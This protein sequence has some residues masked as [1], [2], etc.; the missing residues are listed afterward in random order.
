MS[1]SAGVDEDVSWPDCGP[2][3][4]GA[5][6]H[7]LWTRVLAE[8]AIVAGPFP[9]LTPSRLRPL[10]E[11]G[12]RVLGPELLR[13]F[14]QA[15]LVEAPLSPA[16]PFRHPR[17]LRTTDMETIVTRLC[18]TPVPRPALAVAPRP[19]APEHETP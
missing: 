18:A 11:P 6:V 5:D 8:P 9:G 15:G 13:W 17:A 12:H 1:H 19:E 4:R 7:R 2:M 16:E 10:L 14:D 3:M